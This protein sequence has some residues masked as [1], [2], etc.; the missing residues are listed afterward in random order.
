MCRFS[1]L[2]LNPKPDPATGF[3][4]GD[5]IT[6]HDT[7]FSHGTRVGDGGGSCV[8]VDASQLLANCPEV[9]RLPHGTITAQFLNAPPPTKHLAITGG[10][11]A[12]K[13]AGGEGTL[14]EAGDQTGR[15]TLHLL[16]FPHLR[17]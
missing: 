12:Y 3:G 15:E 10:T 6:F 2:H 5:E 11:G 13:N 4:N 8:I 17:H 9:I 14:V 7:L 1:A 16:R